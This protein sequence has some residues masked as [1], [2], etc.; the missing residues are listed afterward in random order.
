MKMEKMDEQNQPAMP[1]ERVTTPEPETTKHMQAYRR[2]K[3]PKKVAAGRAGAA[4]RKAK[5]EQ[6][7]AELRRAK[8][9]LHSLAV[10]EPAA[11]PEL[12]RSEE[13]SIPPAARAAVIAK[14]Q[15]E[16]SGQPNWTPWIIGA[17][18]VGGALMFLFPRNMHANTQLSAV[19]T[20]QQV[21]SQASMAAKRGAQHLKV[22]PN[23][24]Y[25]E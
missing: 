5:Q 13:A 15:A 2:E 16:S 4:A 10:L 3:D 25:M 18:L 19:P 12:V 21:K 23:P 1:V 20:G 24:F 6:I 11:P 8:E 9:S 14:Q 17:C 7:L 22:S